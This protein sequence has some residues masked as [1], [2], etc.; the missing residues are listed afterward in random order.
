MAEFEGGR[1]IGKKNISV[2][3]TLME[4]LIYRDKTNTLLT[5]TIELSQ[6]V[7]KSKNKIAS[8]FN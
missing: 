7:D 4:N 6:K 1:S 3:R 5:S 2:R 8:N